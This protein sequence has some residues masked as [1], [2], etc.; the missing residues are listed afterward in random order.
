MVPFITFVSGVA[1]GVG[2]CKLYE[3][4]KGNGCVPFKENEIHKDFRNRIAV[5]QSTTKN[6]DVSESIDISPLIPIMEEYGVDIT[7]T[8]GLYNLCNKIKSSTYKK[9]LD[10][11]VEYTHNGDELITFIKNVKIETFE[12]P[13]KSSSLVKHTIPIST[14]D[15]LLSS[16]SISKNIDSPIKKIE[17]LINVAYASGIDRLKKNYGVEFGKLISAYENNEDMESYYRDLIKEIEV[18][19]SFLKS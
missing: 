2:A 7:A 15:N 5:P 16:S 4:L 6:Y 18:S 11:I 10:D 3:F 14:I 9:L 19:R 13:H 12:F 1:V 17:T 8:N